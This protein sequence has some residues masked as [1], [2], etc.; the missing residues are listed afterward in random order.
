[1]ASKKKVEATTAR[2]DAKTRAKTP[3]GAARAP[4]PPEAASPSATP[5][6]RRYVEHRFSDSHLKRHACRVCR[7]PVTGIFVAAVYRGGR[8]Q[9]LWDAHHAGCAAEAEPQLARELFERPRPANLARAAESL[10]AH[11]AS[12]ALD[13][14]ASCFTLRALHDVGRLF[15]LAR[16][17]V[18]AL[19]TKPI[20]GV[21]LA[22]PRVDMGRTEEV[23][24]HVA[25]VLA[26]GEVTREEILERV[27][28]CP[29]S[30]R[31]LADEA[32]AAL[33]EER[34]QG[35]VELVG[36]DRRSAK[37][38]A[39]LWELWFS[40]APDRTRIQALLDGVW[41]WPG[42]TIA[43]L[44]PTASA[45]TLAFRDAVV[46]QA[47]ALAKEGLYAASFC[48]AGDRALLRVRARDAAGAAPFPFAFV[49]RGQHP[50]GAEWRVRV[51]VAEGAPP[52]VASR[53]FDR[54]FEGVEVSGSELSFRARY[55][56]IPKD[57][58][59]QAALR[60][61]LDEVL[62]ALHARSPIA[63]AILGDTSNEGEGDAWHRWSEGQRDVAALGLTTSSPRA[64]T[65]AEVD[66]LRREAREAHTHAEEM[67]DPKA[68][69]E[70]LEAI[71]TAIPA[72]ETALRAE[73]RA[74][75]DDV[76]RL[77]TER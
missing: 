73:V 4:K 26:S 35:E 54:W 9:W 52:S 1:M 66:S 75:R 55:R 11:V 32:S 60:E 28:A 64:L 48:E 13:P 34:A 25:C 39:L 38:E 42:P 63:V 43:A 65:S 10:A 27:R 23:P 6:L 20:E 31:A 36:I 58:P 47:E 61:G 17:G 30:E 2:S 19:C 41:S 5:S 33:G 44:R 16:G 62:S 24:F 45:S 74:L 70:A 76:V 59:Y 53:V 12:I 15:G 14:A 72:H 18:C 21:A 22:G 68:A 71:L 49:G 40:R 57:A 37:R 69:W 56:G 7:E 67:G 46:N 51:R 3:R 50:R 77:E 8:G 29:S